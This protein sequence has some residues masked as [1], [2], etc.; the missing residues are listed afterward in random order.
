MEQERDG[1]AES[2]V[3][4]KLQAGGPICNHLAQDALAQ[5]DHDKKSERRTQGKSVSQ[6]HEQRMMSV[7][8]LLTYPNRSAMCPTSIGTAILTPFTT[9]LPHTP[10]TNMVDTNK[11]T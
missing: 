11:V 2:S 6:S 4:Q 3:Q 1:D 10:N 7:G 8:V 5:D 9:F